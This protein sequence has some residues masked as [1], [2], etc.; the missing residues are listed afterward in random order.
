MRISRLLSGGDDVWVKIAKQFG[1]T[2]DL[3]DMSI[4]VY[5]NGNLEF[6]GTA[7]KKSDTGNRRIARAS[8][9]ATR[10]WLLNLIK[11]VHMKPA[12]HIW[13]MVIKVKANELAQI[14][15]ECGIDADFE[16]IDWSDG[17]DIWKEGD[18]R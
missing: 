9:I 6:M 18:L 8:G 7:K 16:H 17:I 12:A 11:T 2:E 13:T 4:T 14:D 1:I 3:L 5:P 10:E 15:Y